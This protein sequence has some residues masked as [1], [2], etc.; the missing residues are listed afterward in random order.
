MTMQPEQSDPSPQRS[1]LAGLAACRASFRLMEPRNRIA[2]DMRR[3]RPAKPTVTALVT[4]YPPRPAAPGFCLVTS[5]QPLPTDLRKQAPRDHDL[6][7]AVQAHNR[8]PKKPLTCRNANWPTS[9]ITPR[10]ARRKQPGSVPGQEDASELR[11][12]HEVR[13]SHLGLTWAFGS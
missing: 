6:L 10:L 9:Q 5:H 4:S 12:C 2:G 7:P 8:T 13:S 3:T 11:I 1:E